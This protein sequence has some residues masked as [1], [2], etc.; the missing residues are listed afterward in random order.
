VYIF[1]LFSGCIHSLTFACVVASR[2]LGSPTGGSMADE[3]IDAFF[4]VLLHGQVQRCFPVDENVW[5]LAV[6]EQWD[7]TVYDVV[8]GGRVH[9]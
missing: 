8:L 2:L 6:L 9:G 4:V 3:E 5:V 1:A 7:E